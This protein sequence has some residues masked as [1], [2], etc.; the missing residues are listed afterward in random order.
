MRFEGKEQT[1]KTKLITRA[2]MNSGFML[3]ALVAS[4]LIAPCAAFGQ[5]LSGTGAISISADLSRSDV[6]GS[7]VEP[8]FAPTPIVAGPLILSPSLSSAISYDTNVFNRT[9]EQGDG[10][11][12]LVPRLIARANTQRHLFQITANGRIRRFAEYQTENSEEFEVGGEIRYDLS[13]RN[14]IFTQARYAH[15][16]EQRSSVGT[17]ANADEPVAY[18][19]IDGE[20]GTRL[21][22]GSLNVTPSVRL[23]RETYQ[24]LDLTTGGAIDLSFRDLRSAG[25]NLSVGYEF[26]PLVSVFTTLRYTDQNSINP[27]ANLRRAAQDYSVVGG[28]RGE[29]T[30]LLV[31][32]LSAGLRKRDYDEP[33]FR[34][35][36]GFTYGADVEWYPTQ[37]LTF[38]LK[39][40]QTFRNSANPLVAGILSNRVTATGYYDVLRNLR[41][42]TAIGFE[43]NDYRD[44]DTDATRASLQ[45]QAQLQLNRNISVGAFSSVSRQT[46]SGAALVQPYTSFT[47]GIGI[48]LTP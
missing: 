1:M 35:F 23:A 5:E 48:S 45:L 33:E 20:L 22:F 16:I 44:L 34:D 47:T 36:D 9:E 25:A 11:L 10:V 30:P 41:I 6:A 39:A 37:L 42:S 21:S 46:V 15:L 4:A 29:I 40:D 17:I 8:E 12:Y 2:R 3:S 24:D 43:S 18:D 26:S 27:T 38:T 13:E 31:A 28:I 7:R 19:R 32:E 14:S